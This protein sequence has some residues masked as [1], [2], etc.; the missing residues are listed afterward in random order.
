MTAADLYRAMV[1]HAF[2]IE[3]SELTAL[4]EKIT[5]M[6]VTHVRT[7]D[8]DVWRMRPELNKKSVPINDKSAPP[9][10]TRVPFEQVESF[11]RLAA[12]EPAPADLVNA[13]VVNDLRN[14]SA[15]EA[16]RAA[17]PDTPPTIP[18]PEG[19][20]DRAHAV[21]SAS[22]A[23]RWI[24]CPPSALLEADLPDTESD[25]SRQGTAA[26]E[27]AEH[28]LRRAMKLRSD[29]PTSEWQD[30]EMEELTDAYRDYVLTILEET[31]GAELFIE[32]RVDFSHI[33]PGGF[34]TC[35]AVIIADGTMDIIDLKY[36]Q[37]VAVDATGN[38]Q[39]RLYALG[40]LGAFGMLYDIHTIRMTIYQPRRHNISTETLGVAVLTDWARTTVEP[41]AALAANGDGN[42]AAGDHCGFCKLRATCRA[43]AEENLTIARH[44]FADPV[45]LTDEEIADIVL[46]APEITKWLK[47]V[48]AHAA[49]AAINQGHQWPGLKLV[50][51]RSV[52]K[53]SDEH[54]VAAA[55]EA[56]GYTDVW[57]RRLIGITAMQKLMGKKTF[58]EV[59]GDLITKPDGK[60]TLVPASDRRPA[61]ETHTAE[62]DFASA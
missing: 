34:G 29:R 55:A 19:H 14:N 56:A 33:V 25:A 10:K 18:P 20:A 4:Q 2:P 5:A 48:E 3:P 31:P 32:Q 62:D 36:G 24:A 49:S 46:R 44:E 12:A 17:A 40:A 50:A 43:R 45:E 39:L 53:Y 22:G 9:S 1:W 52:R 47:A 38:P 58:D 16:L 59:L 57:D 6:G 51:G 28:K 15:A 27:L 7:R 42:F 35:D 21:L 23:A 61:L 8:G 60:P 11:G 26:H 37:G 54:A 30:D 41:A 13:D